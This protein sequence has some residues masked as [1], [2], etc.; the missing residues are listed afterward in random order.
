MKNLFKA[1]VGVVAVAGALAAGIAPASAASEPERVIV[2]TVGDAHSSVVDLGST[3]ENKVSYVG[4][5]CRQAYAWGICKP[6]T[7][8]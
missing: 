1:L 2:G 5:F 3:V 6:G 7:R 8:K 4:V